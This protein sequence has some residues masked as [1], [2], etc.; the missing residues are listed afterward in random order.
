MDISLKVV[1]A[2]WPNVKLCFMHTSAAV[3]PYCGLPASETRAP[4]CAREATG[5]VRITVRLSLEASRRSARAD[6]CR[7][8]TVLSV[9]L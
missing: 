7:R 3:A 4:A 1:F 9:F 6:V 5:P 8:V 2:T